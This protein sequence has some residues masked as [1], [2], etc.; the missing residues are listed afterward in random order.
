MMVLPGRNTL[1]LGASAPPIGEPIASWADGPWE[2]DTGWTSK[3]TG[4]ST[5]TV[6]S[7]SVDPADPSYA[8][9]VM[10]YWKISSYL[11]HAIGTNN[12]GRSWFDLARPSISVVPDSPSVLLIDPF[13]PLHVSWFS[14]WIYDSNDG[15]STWAAYA[16]PNISSEKFDPAHPGVRGLMLSADSF[17]VDGPDG[18]RSAHPIDGGSPVF[19][20]PR[21]GGLPG[22]FIASA[23]S[24]MRFGRDGGL[25]RATYDVLTSN[26]NNRRTCIAIAAPTNDFINCVRDNNTIASLHLGGPTPMWTEDSSLLFRDLW[27]DEADGRSLWAATIG[28]GVARQSGGQPAPNWEDRSWGL[29][30][31]GGV[32]V[33]NL[34]QHRANPDILYLGVEGRG[35]WRTDTAGR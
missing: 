28:T 35:I 24:Q 10:R 4:M 9:A 29:P 7:L 11:Y 25:S 17:L 18:G 31:D 15:A 22:D 32:N 34:S 6:W 30:S 2:Y 27:V 20:F 21:D 5:N 19:T 16:A 8:F 14:N 26:G 12:G 13:D 1:W 3:N 33:I 23:G